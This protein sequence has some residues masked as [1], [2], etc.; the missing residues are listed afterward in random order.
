MP[1]TETIE[2]QAA[3]GYRLHGTL[4]RPES[5]PHGLVLIHPA[6][7]VTEKLYLSFAEFLTEQGLMAVTYDYRGMGRSA[8]KSLRGF[9]ARMRDWMELDVTA[10]TEWAQQQFPQLPLLAVGHSVGGHALGISDATRH[11]RAAVM[12]ASQAGYIGNIELPSERRRVHLL[13]TVIA[14]IALRLFGYLPGRLGLGGDL[15]AGVAREWLAWCSQPDYFFEDPTL[16]ARRR[17]GD[18]H[19]PLFVIGFDDDLWATPRGITALVRNFRHCDIDR[20]QFSPIEVGVEAIG[21]MGFFRRAMRPRLWPQ[22]S[23]WLLAQLER[24]EAA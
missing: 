23:G 12:V 8:P 10:V 21:H 3:D 17:F 6:T 24:H 5:G 1:I 20:R 11:L 18:K 7:A 9:Q 15:P 13:L 22:V 14:P 16:Q 19:L 4:H 2:I